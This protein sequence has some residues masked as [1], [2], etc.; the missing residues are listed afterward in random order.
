MNSWFQTKSLSRM[1]EDDLTESTELEVVDGMDIAFS[2][3]FQP[4]DFSPPSSQ[5]G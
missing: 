4:L 5:Q 1:S 2:C 3:H